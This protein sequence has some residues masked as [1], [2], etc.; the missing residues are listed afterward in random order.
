MQLGREIER[1]LTLDERKN[2][3]MKKN[4]KY[5]FNFSAQIVNGKAVITD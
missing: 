1:R 2:R 3:N 4:S 5:Y